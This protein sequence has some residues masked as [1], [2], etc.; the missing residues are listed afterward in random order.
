ML[1]FDSKMPP[2]ISCVWTPDLELVALLSEA[3]E[4]LG[5]TQKEELDH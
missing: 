2:I 4:T 1:W 3:L 5:Y